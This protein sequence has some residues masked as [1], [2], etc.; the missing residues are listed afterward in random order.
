MSNHDKKG[1]AVITVKFLI[2]ILYQL[3]FAFLVKNLDLIID[4]NTYNT[5]YLWIEACLGIVEIVLL[6]I[7]FHES[8]KDSFFRFREGLL[9]NIL[10]IFLVF[11]LYLLCIIFLSMLF[12]INAK[13]DNQETVKT[14]NSTN[15]ILN[16]IVSVLVAPFVEEIIFRGIIFHYFRKKNLLYA[17]VG[18]NLLFALSHTLIQIIFVGIVESW[19][20]ILMYFI[21]S[22]IITLFYIWR[23]NILCAIL[24]HM[25]INAFSFVMMNI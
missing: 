2:I 21:V 3:I 10:S 13:V 20:A 8:L 18:I 25:S 1:F 14:L 15:S 24:L 16:G 17:F 12:L 4:K 6:I 9:Y 19:K 5:I 23:K 11:C 7:I 22:G